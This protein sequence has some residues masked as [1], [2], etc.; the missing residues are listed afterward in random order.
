FFL[1]RIAIK[2]TGRLIG[3]IGNPAERFT[4]L[5]HICANAEAIGATHRLLLLNIE[6]H[7]LDIELSLGPTRNT[8]NRAFRAV[9]IHQ[10]DIAFRRTIKF[11]N[12]RNAET[13]LER[14]PDFGA[15]PV[16]HNH[17]QLVLALLGVFVGV[18]QIAAKLA[19]ILE[20]RR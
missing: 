1:L 13:L 6:L 18:E 14:F 2:A 15:Q 5:A 19:N 11:E 8:T 10:S 12:M 4:R 20:E 7:Q 16:A 3:I 17:A 9:E